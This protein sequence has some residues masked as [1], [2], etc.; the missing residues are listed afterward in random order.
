MNWMCLHPL[1]GFSWEAAG[2][3]HPSA[4]VAALYKASINQTALCCLIQEQGVLV[5][6][7]TYSPRGA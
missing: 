4:S 5:Q 1:H 7:C 6:T 2:S 3:L